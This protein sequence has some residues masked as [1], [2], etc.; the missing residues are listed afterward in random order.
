MHLVSMLADKIPDSFA[1]KFNRMSPNNGACR[2]I[3]RSNYSFG[4]K[5]ER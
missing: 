4:A 1:I 3:W 5:Y 2:V